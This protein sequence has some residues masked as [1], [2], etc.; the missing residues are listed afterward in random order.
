MQLL[1]DVNNPLKF[2]W[3]YPDLRSNHI[4]LII[5]NVLHLAIIRLLFK[6]GQSHMYVVSLG[7]LLTLDRSLTI[8]DL[9][10]LN[11]TNNPLVEDL[12]Y[13]SCLLSRI[14]ALA[15]TLSADILAYLKVNR[16]R[17]VV[18]STTSQPCLEM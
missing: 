16:K 18:P 6:P 12:S 11:F 7:S 3:W 8:P 4:V 2:F 1:N 14:K 13:L 5:H 10:S 15:Y 17:H 9:W